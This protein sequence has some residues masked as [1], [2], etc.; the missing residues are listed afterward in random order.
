MGQ[1]TPFACASWIDD[2]RIACELAHILEHKGFRASER[3]KRFLEFIVTEALA[4][5]SERIK[6]YT[7]AVDVFGRGTEFDPSIDPIVRIEA[8]RLRFAL[9]SFY[10]GPGASS[11]VRVSIPKGKYV[12]S[13]EGV[14]HGVGFAEEISAAMIG[15]QPILVL[16]EAK[17]SSNAIA[18][19]AAQVASDLTIEGLRRRKMRVLYVPSEGRTAAHKAFQDMLAAPGSAFAVDINTSSS[20]ISWRISSLASHEILSTE[21]VEITDGMPTTQDIQKAADRVSQFLVNSAALSTYNSDGKI[22]S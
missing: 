20:G 6:A 9:D 14:Q 22:M 18:I 11:E 16:V 13:F 21:R 19:D 12:P 3:N 2:A 1:S 7:I 8:N 5:R 15:P 4:G 10:A 17:P